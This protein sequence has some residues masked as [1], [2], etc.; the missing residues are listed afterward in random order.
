[1]P[2]LSFTFVAAWC[3]ACGQHEPAAAMCLE[4]GCQVNL[5]LPKHFMLSLGVT[6][7]S[8]SQLQYSAILE[9]LQQEVDQV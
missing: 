9:Q 4:I 6:S 7:I 5:A 1:M 3:L 2:N 8:T